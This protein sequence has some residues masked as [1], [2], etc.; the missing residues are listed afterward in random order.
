[1]PL[2][3]QAVKDAVAQARSAAPTSGACE[4]CGAPEASL[5]AFG[6]ARVIGEKTDGSQSGSGVTTTTYYDSPGARIVWLCKHCILPTQ[7]RLAAKYLKIAVAIIV[8]AL[9]LSAV[10]VVIRG[11]DYALYPAVTGLLL[12]LI[13]YAGRQRVYRDIRVA[14][15]Q[16]AQ[17]MHEPQLRLQ[18]YD[19]FWRD[20][21][22]IYGIIVW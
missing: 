4:V 13:P 18:G 12:L 1:M 6:Y 3:S 7:K 19:A 21:N 5:Y 2:I 20:P 16:T 11:W 15:Q 22:E 8:G 14:G 17:E 9:S 10:L